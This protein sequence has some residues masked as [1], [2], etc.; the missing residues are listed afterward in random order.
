MLSPR[1]VLMGCAMPILFGTCGCSSFFEHP[2]EST[3][4]FHPIRAEYR[5][6]A[7]RLRSTNPHFA[8]EYAEKAIGCSPENEETLMVTRD[9]VSAIVVDTNRN[10]KEMVEAG[11]YENA[12]I[13]C[14]RAAA[15][16]DLVKHFP[17]KI[18]FPKI[19]DRGEIAELAAKK[20]YE[21]AEKFQKQPPITVRMARKAVE[22]YDRCL[23]F[24]PGFQDAEKKRQDILLEAVSR[25]VVVKKISVPETEGLVQQLSNE[26]PGKTIERRPRFLEIV[27][28]Q[29]AATSILEVTISDLSF[30]D[31]GWQGKKDS[32]KCA[33]VTKD[34]YGNVL[35][36]KEYSA[37]WTHFTRT[38]SCSLTAGYSVK[39]VRLTDL[40]GAGS[41]KQSIQQAL[42][43]IQW[44]GDK[45][46]MPS[47]L[48]QLSN[49]QPAVP[50]KAGMASPLMGKVIPPLSEKLFLANK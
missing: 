32:N 48:L 7:T 42:E 13:E 3:F 10:V 2:L 20:C 25:V 4:L 37:E 9:L 15:S 24:V 8:L 43:Y 44:S 47:K 5:H 30:T 26:F 21:D 50:N 35:S 11:E 14:D 38:V 33:D 49:T 31:T 19:P 1:W 27:G 39:P 34:K 29:D 18:N 40:P 12:V 23:G 6:E 41:A 22:A 46:A 45:E 17:V 16:A 36:R 28:T